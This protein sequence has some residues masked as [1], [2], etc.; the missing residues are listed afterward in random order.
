MFERM[1]DRAREALSSAQR[2]ARDCGHD[3]VDAPHLLL[4]ILRRKDTKGC[5][6]LHHAGLRYLDVLI[7]V[8][9]MY[10]PAAAQPSTLPLT[11]QAADLLARALQEARSRGHEFVETVHL[12]LACSQPGASP[13]IAP[14]VAGRERAIRE[15]ALAGLA[16]AARLEA[17]LAAQRRAG[18]DTSRRNRMA[19]L[20][21][22]NE[23]RLERA[24]FKKAL[25]SG[26]VSLAEALL[27]PPDCLKTAKVVDLLLAMP[28]YGRVKANKIVTQCRI[29]PSK[30]VGGLSPRQRDELIALL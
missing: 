15:A 1:T 3:A 21:R 23:I 20:E 6:A 24:K 4:G 29:S 22:A 16:R 12:A 2:A 26:R 7:E 14:F 11:A 30:T 8:E 13:S 10:A 25:K 9:E 18:P 17:D 5:E 19:A 28:R 27:D